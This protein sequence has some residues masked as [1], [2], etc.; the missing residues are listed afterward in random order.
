MKSVEILGVPVHSVSWQEAVDKIASFI[1]S[2]KPHQVTTV[3]S[4]FV[5]TAQT[6][7]K[8]MKALQSADLSL[9]DSSGITWAARYHGHPLP[10]RI[11]GAD[12]VNEMAQLGSEKGWKF[13]LVGAMNGVAQAAAETLKQRYPNLKIVGAEVGIEPGATNEEVSSLVS[14][15]NKAKPDILLVAF[16]APKQDLFIYEH[17]KELGVPVMIG[18]GGTFDF[19]A[20]RIKRAPKLF[21]V[22]GIEFAWRLLMEPARWRRIANAT[23]IFPL[24]VLTSR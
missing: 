8:F 5:M 16:G 21:R 6:N 4:E 17:K 13:Y 23:I 11:P 1:E 7:T 9:A 3:N 24:R 10:D 18:V 20:G 14:R 22:L 19:L 15:I 12:L 2:G